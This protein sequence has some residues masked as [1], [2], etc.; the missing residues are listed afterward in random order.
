MQMCG[1]SYYQK[2][3]LLFLLRVSLLQ[4]NFYLVGVTMLLVTIF[5]VEVFLLM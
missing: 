1:I 3:Q 2:Y 4:L 5:G